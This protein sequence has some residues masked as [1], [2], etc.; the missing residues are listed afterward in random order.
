[1]RADVVGQAWRTPLGDTVDTAVSR[2][3]AG[4]RAAT[5]R[6]RFE[7]QTYACRLG[8]PILSAPQR[9]KH[10][11]FL[12]RMGLFGLEAA[13]EALQQARARAALSRATGWAS[14]VGYGG[15]RAH[16]DD[17]MAALAG[18]LP[19]QTGTWERGLKRIHPYWM[20]QHLS[21]NAHALLAADLVGARGWRDLWRSHG[22]GAGDLR[23][24]PGARVGEH[25]SRAWCSP[26]TRCSSPR[27]WWTWP[28]AG[29]R[30]TGELA[31]LAAPYDTHAHG[32]VPGEAAAALVLCSG[33]VADAARSCR[34]TAA[35]G[36]DGRSSEPAPETLAAITSRLAAS[37]HGRS[38]VPDAP[39]PRLDSEERASLS[40]LLG[41]RAQLTAVQAAFGQLGAA[42]A[43]VQAMAL[44]SC[45]R[46]GVLPAIAG[47]RR[48]CGRPAR[49]PQGA[50]PTEA[51]SALALS[52][53]APGLVAAVR[54]E[55]GDTG[56]SR[57]EP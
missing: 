7:T 8:A 15:L 10:A 37:G 3:L 56:A 5:D 47:L 36:G 30:R 11:R 4:E 48:A 41:D 1:M 40:R 43:L 46:R 34:S 52:T 2:L 35:D 21:N 18:Q 44:A 26:T 29:L 17:M 14:S 53:G 12:R 6:P 39:C 42:T 33:E 57:G 24:H 31:R 13:H 25:R 32:F 19:E 51:R 20:L 45:L 28:R 49:A 50:R 23:G 38:M 55:I 9:S 27:R 16:W 22:G 54:V